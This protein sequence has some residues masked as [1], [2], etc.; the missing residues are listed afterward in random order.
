[1]RK[2]HNATCGKYIKISCLLLFGQKSLKNS[3]N[4]IANLITLY[5]ALVLLLCVALYAIIK[6]FNI[7]VGLSTNLLIWSATLFPSLVIVYTFQSWR[8][9]KASEVLA[10]EAKLI[11]DRLN[12][13][14]E[15][16]RFIIFT[17][18]RS[19]IYIE[20]ILQ[21]QSDYDFLSVKLIFLDH[22]ISEAYDP[23]SA[24]L[25]H[26]VKNQYIDSLVRFTISHHANYSLVHDPL[27]NPNTKQMDLSNINQ[28]IIKAHNRLYSVLIKV[29]MHS[30]ALELSSEL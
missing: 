21:V 23:K 6:H 8:A 1:M 16:I 24:Q 20:K 26:E 3:N 7:D 11:A 30:E 17:N 25:F 15:D 22:L 28:K 5:L 14:V 29:L 2:Q 10:N 4:Y 18:F 12:N 27:F 13:Q 9:Q 19:P